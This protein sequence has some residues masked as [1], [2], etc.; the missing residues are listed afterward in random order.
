MRT[1]LRLVCVWMC[2]LYL[3]VCLCFCVCVFVCVC[4]CVC[5]CAFVCVCELSMYLWTL[6]LLAVRWCGLM[7]GLLV[8][9]PVMEQ[10][11]FDL[12]DFCQIIPALYG[13]VA[14][15][16]PGKWQKNSAEVEREK[17]GGEGKERPWREGWG[18]EG[19]VGEE[20]G[21]RLEPEH[22]AINII[23]SYDTV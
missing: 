10:Q 17:W 2:P 19:E 18:E 3:C 1:G 5:V 14:T 12:V 22:P 13:W 4:V 21:N 9:V 20:G 15:S 8:F 11:Q 6:R 7:R 23:L 16:Q